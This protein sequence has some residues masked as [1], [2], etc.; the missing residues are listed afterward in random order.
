MAAAALIALSVVAVAEQAQTTTDKTISG[1]ISKLDMA[2][3]SMVIKDASGNEVTVVWDDAT[4]VAGGELREG[5]QVQ[6]QAKD[7]GGQTRATSI[8]IRSTKPY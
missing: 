8:Q 4:R 7:Q 2:Q 3:K 6:V 5:S 1:T